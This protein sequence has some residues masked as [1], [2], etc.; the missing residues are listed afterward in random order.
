M[1]R[2][3]NIRRL[4]LNASVVASDLDSLLLVPL[5]RGLFYRNKS[6]NR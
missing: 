3:M 1:R 2:V 4:N 6:F 5:S